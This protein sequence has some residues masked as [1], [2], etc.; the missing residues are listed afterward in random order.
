MSTETRQGKTFK[1]LVM[2]AKSQIQEI[3]VS[4]LARV[5]PEKKNLYILDVR[6]PEDFL[7]GHIP[8]SVNIPRGLLELEID[9]I[10]SNQNEEI[11]VYCGG[12]SRSALAVQTL[13]VMGYPKA[14]SLAG[15]YR[16]WT[17]E[18]PNLIDK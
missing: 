17:E 15:G 1:Q 16:L 7:K 10:C 18:Q 12:G 2:E 4:E 6:E 14:V 5:L 9:E 3:T 11:I 8:G 13:A